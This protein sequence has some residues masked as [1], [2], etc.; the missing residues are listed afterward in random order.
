MTG[1]KQLKRRSWLGASLGLISG[2]AS[3]GQ[4]DRS[5]SDG[6]AL[7]TPARGRPE[8]RPRPPGEVLLPE[9]LRLEEGIGGRIG[10]FAFQSRA[11]P[12]PVPPAVAYRA[13]EAFAMCSTFKWALAAAILLEAERGKLQLEKKLSF[14]APD[15]DEY[16]PVARERLSSGDG[17]HGLL[18][19]EECAAAAVRVSD[20]TAAN[21][22]LRELGGPAALTRFF[23]R[24]GDRDTRLDRIEPELNL[25]SPGDPRDTTT[26]RAMAQSLAAVLMGPVL[27]DASRR[28]LVAWLMESATGRDRVRGGLPP[29]VRA[30]DKTGTGA[31]GACNDVVVFWPV[32]AGARGTSPV[33]VS[34]YM[35]ESAAPLAELLA[36]HRELGRVL[37]AHFGGAAGG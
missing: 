4:L 13:E 37:A 36:A 21:L 32:R 18:S 31:N 23:R 20:N 10:V 9:V 29:G 3:R 28:R 2:C 8:R 27:E 17:Q 26:P 19:I 5:T 25:N 11:T 30:G 16:A 15:L 22:L 6:S 33:F 12:G 24:L 35:S 14:G 1:G 7:D 34:A